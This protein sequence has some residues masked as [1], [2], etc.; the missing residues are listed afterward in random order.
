MF[1]RF[2]AQSGLAETRQD[3]VFIGQGRPPLALCQWSFASRLSDCCK[4]ARSGQTPN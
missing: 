1:V 2:R 4:I 3:Q